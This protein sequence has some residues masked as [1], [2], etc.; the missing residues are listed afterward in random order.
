[1]RMKDSA[2][3]PEEVRPVSIRLMLFVWLWLLVPYHYDEIVNQLK[4]HR[5]MRERP[6]QQHQIFSLFNYI[7]LI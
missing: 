1:M 5:Y 3:L 4:Y 2:H 7:G 6:R